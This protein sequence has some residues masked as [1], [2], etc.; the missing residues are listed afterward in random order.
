M[1]SQV[2]FISKAE[3]DQMDPRLRGV[4]IY[5]T[6]IDSGTIRFLP[7]AD[8]DYEIDI[9]GYGG[10]E[11]ANPDRTARTI[12]EYVNAFSAAQAEEEARQERQFAPKIERF[13]RFRETE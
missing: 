7:A 10:V 5:W 2:S 12:D 3:L 11:L 6:R 9:R 1:F 13:D 4:P 8:R